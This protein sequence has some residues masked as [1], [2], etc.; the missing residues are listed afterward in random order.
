MAIRVDSTWLTTTVLVAIAIGLPA[1]VLFGSVLRF[2]RHTA[3]RWTT[4]AGAW[5]GL[6]FMVGYLSWFVN[7]IFQWSPV[8]MVGWPILG[9]MFCMISLG[10]AFFADRSQQTKLFV[11]SVLLVAVSLSSFVAPN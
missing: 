2:S 10:F 6:A 1:T 9:I 11:G 8:G 3:T 7:V 5:V 4:V